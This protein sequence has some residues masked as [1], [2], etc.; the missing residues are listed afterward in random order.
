MPYRAIAF[1]VLV[2]S[3]LLPSSG[4][5]ATPIADFEARLA[6]TH[7]GLQAVEGLVR[8]VEVGSETQPTPDALSA[9]LGLLSENVGA[10]NALAVANMTTEQ[11][12]VVAASLKSTAGR[13][14]DQALLAGGR[15]LAGAVSALQQLESSCLATMKLL[16]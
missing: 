9:Y 8:A 11:K 3:L 16:L 15:G 13:L 4:F 12:R 14:K 1:F 5:A 7:W 10:L 2:S 6:Q